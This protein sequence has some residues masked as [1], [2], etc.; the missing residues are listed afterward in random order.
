TSAADDG[1][2]VRGGKPVGMT[3]T[4]TKYRGPGAVVFN[5]AKANMVDGRGATTASFSEPGDY[6]LQVVVDDGSGE[7]AG[8]F[9]YHCCW[10]NAQVKITVGGQSTNKSAISTLQ[11]AMA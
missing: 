10:T 1:L 2:P 11:S 9:G 7:S 3:F 8:N 6:L 4:W 5:P